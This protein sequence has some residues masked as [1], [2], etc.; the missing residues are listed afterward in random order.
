MNSPSTTSTCSTSLGRAGSANF[1]SRTEDSIDEY[2]DLESSNM[3]PG[4]TVSGA[5]L[6]IVAEDAELAQ[7]YYSFY[8]DV[9]QLYALADLSGGTGGSS[10]DEDDDQAEE[11][12]DATDDEDDSGSGRRRRTRIR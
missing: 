9:A 7:I 4:E 1:V 8:G 3:N 6:Y 12:P 5:V 10:A 11:T 2:P